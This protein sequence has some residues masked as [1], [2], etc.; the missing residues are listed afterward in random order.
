MGL[1]KTTIGDNDQPLWIHYKLHKAHKGRTDG[2]HGPK[3][4]P[5]EPAYIEIELAVDADGHEVVLLPAEDARY[6]EKIG[7]W[8]DGWQVA[9]PE[10]ERA[11]D[12]ED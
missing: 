6:C 8:L 5:D 7:Q 10:W 3:L 11:R 2:R 1:F 9:E 4:E 12:R